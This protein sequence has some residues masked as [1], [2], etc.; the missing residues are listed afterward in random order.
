MNAAAAVVLHVLKGLQAPAPATK[1]VKLVYLVDYIHFQHFGKTITGFQYRWDHYGPNAVDHAIVNQVEELALQGIVRYWEVENFYGGATKN[2]APPPGSD[3]PP[4]SP[5]ARMALDGVLHRY[6]GL[7]V[8]EIT[9][10]SKETAPFREASQYDLLRMEQRFPALSTTEEDL[11]A[12]LADLEENGALSLEE[13]KER[14]GL[15]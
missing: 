12:Y 3:V 2:F 4:L 6:G 8:Q 14:Y 5:E 9:A 1:L 10:K 13:I 11:R 15:A 7:S